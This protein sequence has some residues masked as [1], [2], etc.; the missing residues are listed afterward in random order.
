MTTHAKSAF[1]NLIIAILNT[2]LISSFV[3]IN[4]WYAAGRDISKIRWKKKGKGVCLL[5]VRSRGATS[6]YPIVTFWNTLETKKKRKMEL[7]IRKSTCHGTVNN[8]QTKIRT[9]DGVQ[10]KVATK[11]LKGRSSNI[12][13]Q[14]TAPVDTD[15]ASNACRRTMLRH[16]VTK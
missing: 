8:S 10:T 3:A 7:I 11:L 1:A 6:L 12:P 2:W 5:S 9:F 4:S 15:S 16:H 13:N 14:F